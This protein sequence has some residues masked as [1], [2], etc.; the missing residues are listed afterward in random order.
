MIITRTPMRISFFGGGT[1]FPEFY[2][3]HGGAVL[4][5]TFDKYCYVNIRHLP[6][7]FEYT[8][9]FCYSKLERVKNV[10]EIQHPLIREAME[11][12]D[13][14][15][16]R[17][18]Y[19]ADLPAR[20]GLATSSSFAVGMLSAFHA[21]KGEY[22]GKKQLADEAIRLERELC[23][24]AGGWQDQIA[25][26]YGGLNRIVFSESGYD[27]NPVIIHPD[28]KKELNEC[29]MLF[30][31]GFS[32]NS[33]DIQNKTQKNLKDKVED[34]RNMKQMVDEAVLILSDKR[35]S[36]R[37]FGELMAESWRLKRGINREIS[38]DY[39]DQMYEAARNA[40]AVG[41]KLLGAGGGG[42]MLF[43]VERQRQQAVR[44]ALKKSLY[45]P[46]EFE[47]KGSDIIYFSPE[48]YV[49]Q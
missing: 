21:M 23:K 32:R 17:L 46:F 27:V 41:G 24:E 48:A 12:F 25:V 45:V 22:V 18:S 11:W 33:F 13:M 47:D 39:V 16:I 3:E 34:L 4:S 1:D 38:T 20:T 42:F 43:Y 2:K 15:E 5:T 44:E 19:E 10:E 26:S 9:E 36:L 37:E 49:M 8:S 35:R 14:R 31:T 40:G 6:R 30:F 29:L 28:R 7:F